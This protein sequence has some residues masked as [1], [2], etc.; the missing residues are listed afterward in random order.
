M[1][2]LVFNVNSQCVHKDPECDFSHIVAGTKK[3]LRAKFNFSDDWNGC[4][5][6]AS[7]WRGEKEEAVMLNSNGT[8][9]IP[10]EVLTGATFRVSITGQRNDY[11]IITN[12]II[13]RQE[14]RR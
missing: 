5:K 7:F 14:V 2:L 4:V 12:K 6:V 8:C 10:P 1:R 11:R 3:Y 9:D 13:V